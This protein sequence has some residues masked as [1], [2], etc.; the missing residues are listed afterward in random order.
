M[1]IVWREVSHRIASVVDGFNKGSNGALANVAE[2]VQENGKIAELLGQMQVPGIRHPEL[3]GAVEHYASGRIGNDTPAVVRVGCHGHER[4]LAQAQKI[5]LAQQAQHP[6]G[7]S[8]PAFTP[9]DSADP[10]VAVAAT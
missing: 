2:C 7:V 10:S 8:L 3:I 1:L 9:Q 6:F 5:V 4:G